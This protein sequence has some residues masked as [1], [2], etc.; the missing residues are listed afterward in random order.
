LEPANK[1][2]TNDYAHEEFGNI[3]SKDIPYKKFFEFS[4]EDGGEI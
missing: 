3:F 2:N 4:R 1:N